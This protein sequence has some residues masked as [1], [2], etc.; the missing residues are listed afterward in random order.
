MNRDD[1]VA[2]YLRFERKHHLLIG[3]ALV[4]FFAYFVHFML[5]GYM[6]GFMLELSWR[7]AIAS[8][9]LLALC[10]GGVLAG[11][12]SVPLA[13]RLARLVC[14]NCGSPP[15]WRLLNR[16]V[17]LRTRCKT[18]DL[19]LFSDTWPSIIPA[20]PHA[21]KAPGSPMVDTSKAAR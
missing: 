11:I 3:L 20:D 21:Q 14:P 12:A 1:F 4:P 5:S 9:I 15:E 17:A 18:C 19:Q 16:H 8:S 7:A 6:D 13:L 10:L 2:R